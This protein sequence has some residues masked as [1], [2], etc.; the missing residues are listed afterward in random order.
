MSDVASRHA[1]TLNGQLRPLEDLDPVVVEVV[2]EP[3]HAQSVAVQHAAWMTVNMLARLEGVVS[4][5]LFTAPPGTTLAGRIVPIASSQ[6][7]FPQAVLQGAQVIDIVPVVTDRDGAEPTYRL[8]IG[9]GKPVSNGLRIY[10]EA[11]WGGVAVEHEVTAQTDS[12]LPFG[13]YL[14]ASFGVAEVFKA[15]RAVPDRHHAP[16]DAY[17]SL[18]E[19]RAS[20]VPITTGPDVVH[21]AL[22]YE[23]AG[24]GAVGC[25]AVHALWATPGLTGPLLLTD[26]D[27]AGVDTTNL[28]RY[29]LFG[30]GHVRAPKASTALEILQQHSSINWRAFDGPLESSPGTHRRILCAVDKNTNRA[31]VQALWPAMLIMASTKDFRA[32]VVRCDPRAGGPC[33]RCHNAPETETPDEEWRKRY[34]Q[35]DE[36][37]QYALAAEVGVSAEEA[38]RWAQTG[39]C[40]TAG[41]GVKDVLRRR[42]GSAPMWAVPFVSCAAGTMLAAEAVKESIS[43]PV[44]LSP[45][46]PRSSLQFW[47]PGRSFGAKPYLRDPACP[48][49]A[50]ETVGARFWA[51]AV[52]EESWRGDEATRY[53]P[54]V[55]PDHLPSEH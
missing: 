23:L 16:T 31:A 12:A 20:S 9:P 2:V 14:A 51:D 50:P 54:T 10:G 33:A 4:R 11:W 6:L 13:P 1:G 49:C 40:G 35:S 38:V 43:A 46:R 17:Y 32:E 41:E 21:A 47:M 22:D 15:A 52:A 29:L 48:M 24:V 8:V 25:S 30:M 39:E 27:E 44:P 19:H 53:D 28:N 36:A 7:A 42:E 45:S 26:S 5:V 55:A 18:W 34:L 3:E 37:E